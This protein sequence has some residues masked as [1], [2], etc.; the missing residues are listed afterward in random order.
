MSY[1]A[2]AGTAPDA[3]ERVA[4]EH[5]AWAD[6]IVVIERSHKVKLAKQFGSKLNGKR[7]V[8]LDIPDK[9]TFMQ[10]ELIALL[11]QRASQFLRP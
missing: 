9:Y 7:I 8:C 5:I 11:E 6:I 2:S 10:P 3:E 1:A 4:S